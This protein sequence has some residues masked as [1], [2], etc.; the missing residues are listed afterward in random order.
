MS[1][2]N[3][4]IP[5]EQ[6]TPEQ[7]RKNARKAGI[8][9]GKARRAR[10]TARQAAEILLSLPL[11][12]ESKNWK[13]LK[14]EGVDPDDID[15]MMMLVRAMIEA[16]QKGDVAAFNAVLKVI[17]EDGREEPDEEITGVVAIGDI[18]PEGDE[19]S[20][21]DMEAPAETADVPTE[22]GI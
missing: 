15:N 13:K 16:G 5:N 3:N 10:K 8:A 22:A 20:E 9:S 21:C 12:K 4:L 11:P 2:E 6:R 1:N 7:R 19:P 17:G 14:K 18:L